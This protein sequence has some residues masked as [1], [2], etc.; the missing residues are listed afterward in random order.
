MQTPV[1]SA[2]GPVPSPDTAQIIRFPAALKQRRI[3]RD[4]HGLPASLARL[5]ALELRLATTKK[6]IR[7]A[8]RLRYKVFFEEGGAA[9][10]RT[11]RLVRRDI[12]PYD[13]HCDHLIVIDHAAR[14]RRLGL[15]TSRVVGAYRLLRSDMAR[16]PLGF[17]SAREFDLAPLL[18]R[19]ADKPFLELGRSCV[20]PGYRTR[21]TIDLLWQG[22]G[23]YIAHHGIGVLIG[24]ASLKGRDP[25]ALVHELGFL[26]HF[27]G[28][29][30]AEWRAAALGPRRAPMD[31][32]APDAVDQRAA[33]R[34]L[35]PLI[36]GY[37]RCGAVVGD[38]AVVDHQFG[39]VDVLMV[40]PVA[41]IDP[42]YLR[43]FGA[44]IIRP[45]A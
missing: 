30:D 26:H 16:G 10:D 22:I 18:A 31:A 36:R 38:G 42:R 28:P 12:C 9:P 7:K 5:G 13:R 25:A 34:A 19:H 40:M 24:C 11:A 27:A 21:R 29:K 32:L 3:I 39:T 41:R 6:E 43:Q 45:A 35:P 44:E 23:I 17:Y 1:P 15:R 4:L 37:L 8:Q 2:P 33:L 14:S 20:H